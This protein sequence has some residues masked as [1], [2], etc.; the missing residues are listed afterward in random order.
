MTNK[1]E[2]IIVDDCSTD[3]TLEKII[4]LKDNRIKIIKNEKNLGI[5]KTF[6]KAILNASND[7]IF[8]SDQDDVWT[9]NRVEV[10]LSILKEE[11]VFLVS[12][13]TLAISSKGEIIDYDLGKLK[14]QQS[15]KHFKNIYEIFTGKAAYYGCGMAIR[16]SFTNIILPFP[17]F[18]ESHDLWIA[19]A[20]NI[21]KG[22]KHIAQIIL[23]RRIHGNNSSIIKR[24]FYKKILSRWIFFISFFGLTYLLFQFTFMQFN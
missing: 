3:D 10:M 14:P 7:Y 9:K 6:E 4:S 2:I 20:A 11:N 18:I 13:N 24:N 12:G 22:N 15:R 5:N 21:I 17:D 19:M 1:D 8:L 16:K 23:N